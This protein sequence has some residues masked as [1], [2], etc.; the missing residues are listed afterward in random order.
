MTVS[1]GI[2][3]L[4]MLAAALDAAPRRA[5][6]LKWRRSGQIVTT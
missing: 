2:V 5:D 3:A 4:V 6:R 1:Q